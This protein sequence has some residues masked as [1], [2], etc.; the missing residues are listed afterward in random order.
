MNIFKRFKFTKAKTH[1][2][3]LTDSSLGKKGDII[4]SEQE[5]ARNLLVPLQLAYYVPRVR[6]KALLPPGYKEKEEVS[7]NKQENI[8]PFFTSFTDK[9]ISQILDQDQSSCT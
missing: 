2:I 8:I 7:V 6:G 9:E 1:L 5:I 3:L 4:T